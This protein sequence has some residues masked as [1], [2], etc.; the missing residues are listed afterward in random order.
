MTIASWI[1]G[2]G[3]LASGLV[4]VAVHIAGQVAPAHRGQRIRLQ[5]REGRIWPTVRTKPAGDRRLGLHVMLSPL[6]T[7]RPRTEPKGLRRRSQRS[8][9]ASGANGCAG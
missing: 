5:H 9:A 1:A 2:V 4:A 8:G 6:P 3:M 7:G